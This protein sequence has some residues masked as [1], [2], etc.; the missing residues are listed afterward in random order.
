VEVDVVRILVVRVIVEMHFDEVTLADAD[1]LARHVAAEGPEGIAHAVGEPPLQ[2]ADFQVNDDLGR[3]IAVDRRGHVRRIGQH[4]VLFADDRLSEVF[5]AGGGE[6]G[7]REQGEGENEERPQDHGRNSSPGV[8]VA[9][10]F[11]T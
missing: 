11:G 9:L 5:R 2:F 6:S 8:R 1:E 4:G 3:M 7:P 10:R